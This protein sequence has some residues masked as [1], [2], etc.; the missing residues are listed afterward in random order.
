MC[1]LC[2]CVTIVNRGRGICF[3]QG[4]RNLSKSQEKKIQRFQATTSVNK[5][6]NSVAIQAFISG[7]VVIFVN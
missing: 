3:T 2:L 5:T 6:R 4:G 1:V 7:L